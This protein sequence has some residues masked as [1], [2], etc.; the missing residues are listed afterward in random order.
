MLHVHR[1]RHHVY[2]WAVPFIG[3]WWMLVACAWLC[4]FTLVWS[5]EAYIG[6]SVRAYKTTREI[7]GWV[8]GGQPV[9]WHETIAVR[10]HVSRPRG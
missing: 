5:Y 2:W 8:R 10:S 9:R 1:H 7:F 6:A 3:I 4:L